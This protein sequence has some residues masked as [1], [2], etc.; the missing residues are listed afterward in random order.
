MRSNSGDEIKQRQ[1]RL[2]TQNVYEY[3][4]NNPIKYLDPNGEKAQKAEVPKPTIFVGNLT[5]LFPKPGEKLEWVS[6]SGTKEVISQI[7]DWRNVRGFDKTVRE[8]LANFNKQQGAAATTIIKDIKSA[9]VVKVTSQNGLLEGVKDVGSKQT[10]YFGHS[11]LD[12]NEKSATGLAFGGVGE[13]SI[14]GKDLSKALNKKAPTP[15]C[16]ACMGGS[17]E[18]QRGGV[19]EKAIGPSKYTKIENIQFGLTEEGV[20][21]VRRGQPI[22]E[23]DIILKGFTIGETST[24]P[25]GYQRE[26]PVA[27]PGTLPNYTPRGPRE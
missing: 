10:I 16:V 26:R 9:G 20:T 12:P 14:S 2:I 25:P 23:K 13:A 19:A 3:A 15:I 6:R 11:E 7:A 4:Y 5:G 24:A 1:Y 22:T 17:L 21:K 8:A 27:P 18:L